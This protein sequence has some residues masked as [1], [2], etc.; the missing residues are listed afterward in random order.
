MK[1]ASAISY[2]WLDGLRVEWN[3][4]PPKA[5]KTEKHPV[6]SIAEATTTSCMAKQAPD[7]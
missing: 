5:E 1:Y 7:G 6:F 4:L 2:L 3:L